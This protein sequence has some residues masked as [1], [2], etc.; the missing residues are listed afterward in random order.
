MNQQSPNFMDIIDKPADS[1]EAPKPLAVGNY[2]GIISGPYTE[3]KVGQ[4]ETRFVS[5]PIKLIQPQ[6]DVDMAALNESLSSK[7]GTVKPL[8]DVKMNWDMALTDNSA[9]IVLDWMENT[10][11]IDRVGKTMR[12]MLAE[13]V[14]KQLI[15]T[16]KHGMTKGNNPRVFASITDTAKV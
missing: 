12:Q 15:C 4:N 2:L 10:L 9:H 8:G 1:I 7:D 11:G 16:V 3:K 5:W 14:G 6:P 13:T